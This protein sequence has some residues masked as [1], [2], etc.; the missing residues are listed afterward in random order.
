LKYCNYTVEVTYLI[1]ETGVQSLDTMLGKQAH[2]AKKGV[3]QVGHAPT[4]TKA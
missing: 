4:H 3:G 1:R 2:P